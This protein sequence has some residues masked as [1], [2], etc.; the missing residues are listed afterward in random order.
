MTEDEYVSATNL[1]KARI[2]ETILRDILADSS[3]L[4]EAIFQ[5]SSFIEELEED[6]E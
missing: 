2:A 3:V 1:C 6:Q 5:L 4:K